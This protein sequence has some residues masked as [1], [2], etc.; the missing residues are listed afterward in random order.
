MK[1]SKLGK[2]D[3]EISQICLG[4]MTWGNQNSQAEGHAQMDYALDQGVNFFDTAEMYAV[5]PGPDTYGKTEEIIGNWFTKSGNRDKIFLASKICGR[6]PQLSW[7]RKDADGTEVNRTNIKEAIENSL[8]RLQTAHID[9]YQI[10]WPD[11]PL[12]LFGG[13]LTPEPAKIA[14]NPITEQLSA[15]QELVDEGKIRYL[16]VSNETAW[17]VMSFTNAARAAGLPHIQ[18]IQN[19]YNLVNRAFEQDLS[20]T[21]I[22]EQVSGLPYS[23]LGQGYLSGKYR[24]GALPKGSRKERD[25]RLQR[26]EGVNSQE[27]I[28]A[29]CDLAKEHGLD[30]SQMAIQF[31]QSR[32]FNTSTI[33]GATSLEQLKT[34]IAAIDVTLT[35]EVLDGI[36]AI[37]KRYPNPC[38]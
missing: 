23:P 15:F 32:P 30:P 3:I 24:D 34:D 29:Y 16:G 36:E 26:Y 25:N 1:Y 38:P 5:P 17:G 13:T 21:C 18:S 35:K 19:A 37:H 8:R 31:C 20:E 27:A 7:A 10:H 33:I 22:N 14:S 11:R 6:H 2:T 4:T 12:N 9:L 28:N